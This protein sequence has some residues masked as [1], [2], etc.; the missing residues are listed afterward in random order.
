M[1]DRRQPTMGAH[2]SLLW[3]E[4]IDIVYVVQQRQ[5]HSDDSGRRVGPAGADSTQRADG[6]LWR[7]SLC[8][9]REESSRRNSKLQDIKEEGDDSCI[10]QISKHGANDGNDEE[11]LDGIAVFIA[12]GTHA[13]HRIGGCAQAEATYSCTQDGSIII[14]DIA[15]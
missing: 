13:G 5:S 7:R 8:S 14:A 6:Q 1:G 3:C 11:R 10:N 4:C 15:G 9:I 12:Y 2:H